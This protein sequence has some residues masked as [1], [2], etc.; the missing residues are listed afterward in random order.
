MRRPAR[1]S[2]ATSAYLSRSVGPYLRTYGPAPPAPH[3]A[4]PRRA[5]R[6]ASRGVA[7]AAVGSDQ[8]SPGDQ[9]GE[10]EQ[11][12]VFSAGQY[13]S[14]CGCTEVRVRWRTR[15]ATLETV[16]LLPSGGRTNRRSF[17]VPP[18]LVL[19]ADLVGP[20]QADEAAA[21]GDGDLLDG[22]GGVH[23]GG[24]AA[25][26]VDDG[27]E[28][29]LDDVAGHDAVRLPGRVDRHAGGDDVGVLGADDQGQAAA[30]SSSTVCQ[31]PL[32]GKVWS[33]VA[34]KLLRVLMPR[35]PPVGL[36]M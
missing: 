21:A 3:V 10:L 22:V 15:A 2:R 28:A 9:P 34:L 27:L 31:V 5:G 35:I 36:F 1:N 23:H 13:L 8:D 14:T 24:L 18:S 7:A 20:G 11:V 32:P 12:H 26:V 30:S 25:G 4:V 6:G 17:F 19:A 16:R 33:W 29:G